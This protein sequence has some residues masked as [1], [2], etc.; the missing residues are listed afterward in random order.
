M[1][2]GWLAK[3]IPVEGAAKVQTAAA[4]GDNGD[5]AVT[6]V[7]SVV[8]K[9]GKGA[10]VEKDEHGAPKNWPTR[11]TVVFNNVSSGFGL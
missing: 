10:D 8:S 6:A 4:S 3:E 5:A 11:G 1:Q 2:L 7:V 9:G